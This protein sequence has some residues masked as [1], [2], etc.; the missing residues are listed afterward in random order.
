M[1]EGR[2]VSQRPE[3]DQGF[4][5]TLSEASNIFTNPRRCQNIELVGQTFQT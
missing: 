1:E 3:G 5:S 4:P 2:K